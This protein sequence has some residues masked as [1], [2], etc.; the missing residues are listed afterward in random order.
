M[1]EKEKINKLKRFE[2]KLSERN[3]KKIKL[4]FEDFSVAL[5]NNNK[6]SVKIDIDY[7]KFEEIA[8]KYL[9][10]IF[11]YN[12]H[13]TVNFFSKLFGWQISKNKL[14]GIIDTVLNNHNKKYAAEKV[15]KITET[16]KKLLNKVLTD[17]QRDGLGLKGTF[18]RILEK[19]KEMGI[20]RAKTIARTETSMAINTTSFKTAKT[21]KIKKKKWIHLGGAYTSRRNHQMLNNKIINIDEYFDLGGGIRCLYPHESGLQASEVVNCNCLIIFV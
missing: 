9:S 16:T 21:A 20:N 19:V 6:F 4:M 12:V 13:S 17:S 2:K 18:N 7:S 3:R 10:E 1:T 5:I 14:K 11:Y 15:T 8:K